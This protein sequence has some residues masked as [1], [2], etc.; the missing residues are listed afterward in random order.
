MPDRELLGHGVVLLV[1]LLEQL[2]PGRV[3]VG[4]LPHE[5]GHGRV[6][7]S[8][9]CHSLWDGIAFHDPPDKLRAGADGADELGE[10]GLRFSAPLREGVIEPGAIRYEVG[11]LL[12]AR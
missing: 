8:L 5:L 12:R 1:E 7:S 2:R 4:R 9:C 11:F 6:E 3:G 10:V